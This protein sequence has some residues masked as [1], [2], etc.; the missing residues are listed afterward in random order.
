MHTRVSARLLADKREE[1]YGKMMHRV[2]FFHARPAVRAVFI[3]VAVGF[4]A[5]IINGL[6]G[7]GGGVIIVLVLGTLLR[8]SQASGT[9]DAASDPKDVYATS[10]LCMLPVS[11]LSA[12]QYAGAAQTTQHD[13]SYYLLPAILGGI[14]G[15]LLLHRVRLSSLRSLFA[16]LLLVSG[17]RML[18]G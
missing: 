16:I 10:L 9:A 4:L 1:R 11:M 15:G 12:L 14:V 3:L 18:F 8:R 13:F 17:I 2:H 5:G 7:A 6:L